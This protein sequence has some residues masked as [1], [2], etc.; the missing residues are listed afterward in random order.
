MLKSAVIIILCFMIT[1][2]AL[3]NISSAGSVGIIHYNVGRQSSKNN[4][5]SGNAGRQ[6]RYDKALIVR[7]A[8]YLGPHGK[9]AAIS[10]GMNCQNCHNAAGTKPFG[11]NLYAVAAN[12]PQ[13]MARTGNVISTAGR[14][15]GCFQRSLNGKKLDTASKEMRAMVAYINWLG[16]DVAKG[17]KPVG[18][19]VAKL[20]YPDHAADTLKGRAVFI[21]KCMACHGNNGQGLLAA[22]RVVYIYPPLW[23]KHSYNDGAGLYRVTS[24]AGFVKN[25]MP[26]GSTYKNPQLTDEEAWNVAAFVNSQP[27]PH[28]DQHNDWKDIKKKPIDFPYGPYADVFNEQQHKYGPFGPIVQAQ[29]N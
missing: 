10:N 9:I 28:F 12:Y 1:T 21:Q 5:P 11:L 7:T 15:N 24:F 20:A 25:N 4:I 29:K 14:I 26:Y 22:D 23:G 18:S 16:R 6:I 17:Q 27:R 19:G 8:Y 13:F 3:F 2:C